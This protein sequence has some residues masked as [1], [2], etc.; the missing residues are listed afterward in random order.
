MKQGHNQSPKRQY[1]AQATGPV[2]FLC[3]AGR[4]GCLLTQLGHAVFVQDGEVVQGRFPVVD[5]LGPL[6]G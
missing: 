3:H 5:R 6:F 4:A 1:F 2:K